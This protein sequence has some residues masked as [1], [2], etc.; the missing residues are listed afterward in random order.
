MSSLPDKPN[1]NGAVRVRVTPRRRLAPLAAVL[2][3]LT[4]AGLTWRLMTSTGKAGQPE[5]V[6][7]A[8]DDSGAFSSG[9][10]KVAVTRFRN[11]TGES[12][13]NIWE[14]GAVHG[15]SLLLARS[16]LCEVIPPAGVHSG[17]ER[18][19]LSPGEELSQTDRMRLADLTGAD[20][21][22]E[23]EFFRTGEGFS[24]R[25][26]LRDVENNIAL[27][28]EVYPVP[29]ERD[30]IRVMDQAAEAVVS[31]LSG[32]SE[33]LGQERSAAEILT[34]GP[35]AFKHFV[36]GRELY[37]ARRLNDAAT[38]LEQALELDSG[39][40]P[41]IITLAEVFQAQGRDGSARRTLQSA[42]ALIERVCDR[43]RYHLQ[44]Q[45]YR[46]SEKTYDIAA[47]IYQRLLEIYP[48]DLTARVGL[49][50]IDQK[51]GRWTEQDRV[52][53][54]KIPVASVSPDLFFELWEAYSAEGDFDGAERIL[55]AQQ[56]CPSL[57]R[58][59]ELRRARTELLSSDFEG[60][61]KRT[62]KIRGDDVRGAVSQL[63]GEILQLRGDLD[64]ARIEY[65]RLLEEPDIASRLRG[66]ILL[67]GLLAQE[68][69][70]S[71]ALK[72][73]EQGLELAVQAGETGWVYD[74]RLA[75]A[76]LHLQMEQP[77]QA[78]SACDAAWAIAV[79]GETP[80]FPRKALLLRGLAELRISDLEKARNTAKELRALCEKGPSSDRMRDY[81]HLSGGIAMAAENVS[82]ALEYFNKA[83][84]L[85]PREYPSRLQR[86]DQ[87]FHLDALASAHYRARFPEEARDV[88]DRLAALTS[89]RIGYG[90][91]YAR[92]LY[93]QGLAAES[94]GDDRSAG[95]HYRRF[96]DIW[97]DADNN[98]EELRDA[99]RR[100][101]AI[102]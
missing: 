94:T 26:V 77:D 1:G 38:A 30:L 9:N 17:L 11:Q 61:W 44:G 82:L 27:L 93:M 55:K 85:L 87:A 20:H 2:V 91:L 34:A 73:A 40:V 67:L 10:P 78:L 51:L 28:E 80:D 35:E 71:Q 53:L 58:E 96:I 74:M 39:F 24:A 81:Y 57:F 7:A 75:E 65:S 97:S 19:N 23:G 6:A 50:I 70:F 42:Q 33:A 79:R 69:R 89:G 4:A 49:A 21:F 72:Q 76:R 54:R 60:A 100:M 37:Y 14:S 47:S 5:V 84:A 102:Q 29:Y 88:Y 18:M 48:G 52:E 32:S 101:S 83:V 15:L 36:S 56:E 13:W 95:R 98:R 62:G 12:D 64:E 8:A 25:M 86:G 31:R 3:L 43:G 63:K 45:Y 66:H 22:L 46:Q 92:S 41:A 90:D 68:G 16:P 99:R 59:I